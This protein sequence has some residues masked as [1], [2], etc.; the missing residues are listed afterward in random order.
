MSDETTIATGA[1]TVA[2]AEAGD[3]TTTVVVTPAH[4]Q[5]T[6]LH[7][8]EF[9]PSHQSRTTDKHYHYFHEAHERLKKAGKL[10]C[11]VC[12]KDGAAAGQPIELHHSVV[13]FALANGVDISRFEQLFP[14][15]GITTDEEFFAFVEGEGNLTP[16]CKLHH[17]G[18]EGIHCLPYPI[19]ESL[20][21]WRTDLPQPGRVEVAGGVAGPGAPQE[22]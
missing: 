20:R 4:A 16:L 9:Y 12:G 17:T 18:I 22:G 10:V 6:T 21:Y 8:L 2:V 13:E 5:T 19:W 7:L 15:F 3:G 14:E 1:A 11:F